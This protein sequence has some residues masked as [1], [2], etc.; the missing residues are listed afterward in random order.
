MTN[1]I[2]D[3]LIGEHSKATQETL[4]RE[5]EEKDKQIAALISA[6]EQ[7][8]AASLAT[9]KALN[10]N[11]DLIEVSRDPLVTIGPDDIIID[12][13]K[14]T[15]NATG[16]PREKLI[17]TDFSAY[18]TEPDKAQAGYEKA[19]SEGVVFDY[20]LSL[21]HISGRTTPVLYNA[22]VYR[23]DEGKVI[24]VFAAA[25]DIAFIQNA[26]N[27]LTYLMNNLE[28]LVEK[29]VAELVIA[30][31]ELAFQN[32][33]KEKRAA[34]LVI[35]NKELAFQ[36]E[37]KDKR[38][39]EL[40]LA[41][42]ELIFQKG[43]KADRAAELVIANKELTF[44]K[45]KIHELN[46]QLE[47]RVSERTAQLESVNK[48]LEAL[49]YS[50]S[51]DLKAPLR[52]MAGYVSLLVKKYNDLLPEEG[53]H[54]LDMISVSAQNMA[55]LIERLLQFSRSGRIEMN[56]K[57]LSMNEIVAALIQPIK[58]QAIEHWIEFNIEPMPLVFGDPDMI[59]SVWS[60][61]I[62]NAVKFSRKKDLT[63]ISIGAEENE[64]DIVYH[65]KDNGA[66]FDMNYTSKLFKVFQRLHSREDYEGTGIGLATVQR[67]IARHGGKIWAESKEGEDATFY[68][69][70]IKRKESE[71]TC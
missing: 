24:G 34:E 47:Y 30:N 32:E 3:P 44:Q 31:K 8:E 28:L 65:I 41:N 38:A 4:I 68:F 35:A 61:L 62:E 66:G 5:N 36:N 51:H 12:A 64:N 22:T 46:N 27:E 71:K 29:R 11:R 19:L 6:K 53:H 70:L 15:E 63:K 21:K 45:E 49:S 50:I 59:K 14:A 10:Y 7:A 25:R 33:E 23:D 37:E 17:G 39:A 69:T 16:L 20:K 58:E 18:F 43:E 9:S 60:N 54:Y 56:Q 13:N 40:V 67:I 42:K 2:Y 57:L 26:K 52:H 1:E 55:E 48:E